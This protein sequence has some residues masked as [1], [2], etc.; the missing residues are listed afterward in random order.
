[1]L[2]STGG[3]SANG[4]VPRQFLLIKPPTN[5]TIAPF[6]LKFSKM[7]VME[8]LG[9]ILKEKGCK[10]RSRMLYNSGSHGDPFSKVVFKS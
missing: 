1:M 9:E 4:F 2:I 3:V 6:V 8:K 7:K 5:C 10:T